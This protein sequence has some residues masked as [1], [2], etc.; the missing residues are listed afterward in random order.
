MKRLLL[1]VVLFAL[2]TGCST[3]MRMYRI[4]QPESLVNIDLESY[5]EKYEEYDSV[6]LF[7]ENTMEHFGS[8]TGMGTPWNYVDGVHVRKLILNPDNE[9]NRTITLYNSSSLAVE[10]VQLLIT[11]PDNTSKAFTLTDFRKEENSGSSDKYKFVFP[12]VVKG[13]VLDYCYEY[14]YKYP[15]SSFYSMI[16][17]EEYLQKRIPCEELIVRYAFPDWWQVDVKKIN[18]D[19][20]VEYETQNYD[21]QHKKV[22]VCK[23]S[24]VPALKSETYSPFYKEWGEYFEYTLQDVKMIGAIYSGYD[25]WTDF[26]K[27][28]EKYALGKTAVFSSRV[29]NTTEDITRD[30]KTYE[31]K[32]TAI[33]DYIHENVEIQEDK[34]ERN[35]AK[36]LKDGKGDPFRITGLAF[37]MIKNIG[38]DP[39][40]IMIHT[41]REGH[42]DNDFIAVSQFSTPALYVKIGSKDYYAFPYIKYI[43]VNQIPVYAG[44]Q[45][46]IVVP[47]TT[48]ESW[49]STE[50]GAEFITLPYGNEEDNLSTENYEL[51]IDDE[52]VIHVTEEKI[53]TGSSAFVTREF[54]DDIEENEKD[55]LI[56]ELLTYTDG[57][58]ELISYEIS[59]KEDYKLPLVITLKYE[60]DNLIMITPEE[61]IFQT[62]GLF[63]AASMRKNKIKTD[64]RTNPIKIYYN[65][66]TVK[67]INITYPEEWVINSTF[68]NKNYDNKFGSI[69]SEYL[70]SENKFIVNQELF[71]SNSSGSAEEISDLLKLIGRKSR[72]NINSINFNI[73]M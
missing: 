56:D 55:K 37:E 5:E 9:N 48:W 25:S 58:I 2:L 17:N 13:C 16:N 35:Y 46:A 18:P 62:G 38:L 1:F 51:E 60:I 71:L 65:S 54:L 61:V 24:D 22:Y 52:G 41:A 14:R 53:L 19:F 67:N 33:I 57:D 64:E 11:Y 23:R 47:Q 45:K 50:K 12:N 10:N 26:T 7:Y 8:D 73:N 28:F 39:K 6:Y 70:S 30:C 32:L 66:K 49:D 3:S 44:G 63:S 34:K 40:L 4:S 43:G 59:N 15:L 42:F 29:E 27:I 20:M 21:E 68:E 31:E 72:V 69:K 36:I